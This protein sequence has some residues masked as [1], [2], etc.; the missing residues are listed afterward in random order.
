MNKD[1]LGSKARLRPRRR[2]EIGRRTFLR[3]LGVTMSLP[4]LESLPVWAATAS[5]PLPKRFA[6][7][8]MACGINF[9]NWWAK[10]QG[11]AMQL[12][13]C[14]EPMAPH[15]TRM[16]VIE[17]LFNRSAVGVGIHP[18]Q[19]GNLLSGAPLQK[20]AELKGG[21]S[22]DQVLANQIGA[23]SVQPSLVLGCEQPITGYHETNFSMAYSSHI[24]WSSPTSPVPME[25]YPSLAFDSL[26]ENRGNAVNASILDRV[27][28]DVASLNRNVSASDKAKLDEYLTSVRDVER[29]VVPARATKAAADQVAGKPPA[30]SMQR[31]Q[32]GLP[33]DVREHMRLMTDI[34]ALGFQTDKTRIA[35]LLLCRDISGM[36]YPFLGVRSSHHPASHNDESEAYLKVTQYY[37]SQLAYLTGRLGAMKEGEGTVLDNSCLLFLSNMWSGKKHDATR[38]PV[39]QAGNLG[40]TIKTGRVLDFLAA[41]DEKR[42]LCSLYLS[43]MDRMGVRQESFGDAK[44]RL[45]I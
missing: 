22:V 35:T 16:N 32:N 10:G 24:S 25:V 9:P 42:K 31:P 6:A 26:F 1:S 29:R 14:L 45:A 37:V 8:F 11:A 17:G 3:G 33:E 2:P 19:T 38:L 18:G 12:G 28:E 36:C 20:G 39:I 40:G 5:A 7:L 23:E 15:K 43:I 34:I 21:I 44:E 41:G 30:S 27:Q 4:W 13:P